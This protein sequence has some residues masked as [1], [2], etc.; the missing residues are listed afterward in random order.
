MRPQVPPFFLQTALD[1]VQRVAP[2]IM[3]V[4]HQGTIGM[5]AA[6]VAMAAEEWD[7]A[8]SRRLEENQ[9]LRQLFRDAAPVVKDAALARRL[10][11]LAETTDRDVRISTLEENNCTLRAALIDLHIHVE[12]QSGDDMRRLETAIWQELAR[13]TERRRFSTSPF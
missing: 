7:R 12:S 3:P 2:G 10:S 9:A 8:G 13:S 1:L 5:V 11:E 6:M 4:Y